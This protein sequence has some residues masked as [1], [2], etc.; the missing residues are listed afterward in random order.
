MRAPPAV[1][2]VTPVYNGQEFLAECIQSVLLQT[3]SN[4]EYVIVDNCSTDNTAAIAQQFASR[5]PRIRLVHTADFLDALDNHTRAMRALD[6]QSRYCKVLH[7]DDWLYPECL[8]RMVGVAE[9]YPAVGIVSSF[10]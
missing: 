3:Y 9:R 2:V 10:R 7:A 4:W 5:E 8:E 6:P 1:S